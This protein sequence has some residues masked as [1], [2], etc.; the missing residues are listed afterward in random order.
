MSPPPPTSTAISRLA[1]DHVVTS[2]TADAAHEPTPRFS[3]PKLRLEVRDL[4]HPG[5]QSFLSSVVPSVAIEFAV[6]KVGCV[7]V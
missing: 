4:M 1:K 5:G 3:L 7:E 2:A 6:K